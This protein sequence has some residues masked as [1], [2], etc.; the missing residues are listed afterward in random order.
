[1]KPFRIVIPILLVLLVSAYARH[2]VARPAPPSSALKQAAEL[3][4]TAER[5]VTMDVYAISPD[6]ATFLTLAG[7]Q[8]CTG[9]TDTFQA[10]QCSLVGDSTYIDRASVTWSPDNRRI[11]FTQSISDDS[12][13]AIAYYP[14]EPGKDTDIW[15][16]EVKTGSLIDLTPEVGTGIPTGSAVDTQPSWSPDGKKLAFIRSDS[17][18]EGSTFLYTISAQGGKPQKLLTLNDHGDFTAIGKLYWT[19]DGSQI[20]YALKFGLSAL[21]PEDG[22]WIVDRDGKHPRQLAGN[23]PRWNTPVLLDVSAKHKVALIDYYWGYWPDD[24]TLNDCY[25]FLLDLDTGALTPLKKPASDSREFYSPM[26]AVF[27]PDGS[28]VV[29]FYIQFEKAERR[30]A[31]LDVKDGT[32][33]VLYTPQWFLYSDFWHTYPSLFWSGNDSIY[34]ITD[35]TDG[36]MLTVGS[37]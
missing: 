4:I 33:A 20:V 7:G 26:E 1:V 27:S 17:R 8:L 3:Q 13:H 22:I 19:G 23:L 6:G 14:N 2:P 18:Q 25:I 37:K 10:A 5:M 21:Y 28:K 35:F 32:E 24:W 16:L 11:A 36:W 12:I 31:L 29:Y 15:V 9:S 34:A 30:L